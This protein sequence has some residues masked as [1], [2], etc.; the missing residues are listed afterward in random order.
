MTSAANQRPPLTPKEGWLIHGR[1]VLRFRSTRWDGDLQLLEITS[2]E[3][4]P[5]HEIPWVRSAAI[6]LISAVICPKPHASGAGRGERR[7]RKPLLARSD[8]PV[9][10]QPQH[11]LQRAGAIGGAW[12]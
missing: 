10:R 12:P 8:R 7:K 1:Q 4:L 6:L 5:D 3:L 11:Q 2:G 9:R